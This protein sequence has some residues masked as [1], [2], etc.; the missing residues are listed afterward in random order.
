MKRLLLILFAIAVIT[1]STNNLSAQDSGDFRFGFRT[2]YYFRAKAYAVGVY[3]NYGLTDWLNIEPGINFMCKKKSTVDVYCDLQIPLEIATYW[4]VYPIV[5]ISAND[6]SAK[7]GSI[8]G[9]AAG[10][11]LGLGTSYEINGHWNLSAQA[12]WMG[13]IP[14]KHRSAIIIAVGIGYNF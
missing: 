9:W 11:N 1:P 13:R 3:G 8:D 4:Y 12:K 7:N 2:G 5:G 6:I 10:L 14:R